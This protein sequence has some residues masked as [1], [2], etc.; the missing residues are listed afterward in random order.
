[1][2]IGITDFSPPPFELERQVLGAE[3]ELVFFGTRNEHE[4]PQEVLPE[5]D[6]LLVWRASVGP[7]TTRQLKRCRIVV[8]YGVG[9]DALDWKA[10]AEA[11]I[12]ACNT[13]DYGT[14]EVADTAVAMILAQQRRVVRYDQ[15]C[16]TYSSGW[17]EHT[18]FTRRSSETSIGVVGVGRIGTAV[19]N[20][21]KPFGFRLLGYDPQ[22]PS[23]HEK[24]V[25]YERV[26]KLEELLEQADVLTFHCPL[27]PETH[28]MINREL[29]SRCRPGV[30]L[31]NTA[32]GAVLESLEVL[33]EALRSGRVESA[34]LDV[35]PQEPPN[36]HPLITAWQGQD[37]WIRGR[38]LINPHSA[39]YSETAW[40]EMRL[41]AAETVRLYLMEGELRNQVPE[42]FALLP[43]ER[44][45]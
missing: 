24:A 28:G 15:E 27:T 36:T 31:V 6:A 22:Q 34:A 23:G 2:R 43:A 42:Q 8:R 41:K 4:F 16:R 26:R 10:L 11:G 33:E 21:L 39:F 45:R 37:D 30:M 40:Q 20:R 17:Q 7:E 35:L 44:M 38:L 14:E 18:R 12:P 13:P 32:R 9:Y 5:L 29:L 3:A 19:V 25:G 1:L